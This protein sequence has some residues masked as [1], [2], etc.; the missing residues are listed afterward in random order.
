M[1]R[2]NSLKAVKILFQ[3]IYIVWSTLKVQNEV[4]GYILDSNI[5]AL[6][7]NNNTETTLLPSAYIYM[8]RAVK[9]SQHN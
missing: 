7:K 4:V 2:F 8:Y 9:A 1:I 5:K 6:N 3:S